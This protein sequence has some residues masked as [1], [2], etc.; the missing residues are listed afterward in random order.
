M[1]DKTV[2]FDHL[3]QDLD[4]NK[5]TLL[6]GRILIQQDLPDEKLGSLFLPQ[7]DARE[8]H[9]ANTGTV[10]AIGHGEFEYVDEST[11]GKKKLR[12]HPGFNPDEIGVGDK[13]IFRLLLSDLNRGRIFTDVRRVDGVIE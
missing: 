10:L 6:P 7:R 1:I 5:I 11:P 12:L 4:P 13:V 9:P 3:V 2:M 8:D